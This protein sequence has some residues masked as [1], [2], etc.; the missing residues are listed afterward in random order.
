MSI[1]R[2]FDD[3]GYYHARAIEEQIAAQRA[4]CAEARERHDEMALVYRF[5]ELLSRSYDLSSAAGE[6]AKPP[7]SKADLLY[8]S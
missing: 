1:Q 7:M 4:T 3:A 2:P 8:L 5:K 6:F